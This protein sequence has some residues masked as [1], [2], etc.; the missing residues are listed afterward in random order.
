MARP[1]LLAV[2]EAFEDLIF[3]GLARL[4][5]PGEELKTSAFTRSV[6]GGAV[7]TAIA[8]VRLGLRTAVMSGLAPPATALLKREGVSFRNLRQE[9]E[10]AALSVALSTPKNRSFVT[11]TGMN[12]ALE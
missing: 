9:R 6:G 2:G 4:P 8:A 12:E 7:I 11:F 3:H 10:P 5:R 1:D